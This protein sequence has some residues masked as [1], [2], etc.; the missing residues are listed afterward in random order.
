MV[1]CV[2]RLVNP[3]TRLPAEIA[4]PL[5]P[6]AISASRVSRTSL[7]IDRSTPHGLCACAS[8]Y[9]V[10]RE[11]R[12]SS[13]ANRLS[14]A[15]VNYAS[16]K[17]TPEDVLRAYVKERKQ[18]GNMP[19]PVYWDKNRSVTLGA[20]SMDVSGFARDCITDPS[21]CLDSHCKENGDPLHAQLLPLR[22]RK[23]RVAR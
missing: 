17:S 11:I 3:K 22:G 9:P 6:V 5:K 7:H 18:K 21:F 15:A 8:V 23:A 14:V 20:S 4:P 13:P 2:F 12:A 10:L 16:L 1:G 19:F